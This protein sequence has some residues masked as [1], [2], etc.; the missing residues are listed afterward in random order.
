MPRVGYKL[1]DAEKVVPYLKCKKSA[2]A[3]LAELALRCG[4]RENEIAGLKGE[5]ID[6]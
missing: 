5:N 4:L 6:E 3:L 2:Y 1:E